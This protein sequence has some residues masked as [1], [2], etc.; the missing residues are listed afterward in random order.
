MFGWFAQ[1]QGSAARD[2]NDDF[3]FEETPSP[4]RGTIHVTHETAMSLVTLYACIK[5][6]AETEAQLP[7]HLL[8][9]KSVV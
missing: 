4:S 6:I 7:L 9:R 8:D 1:S 5:T 3:W 2:P